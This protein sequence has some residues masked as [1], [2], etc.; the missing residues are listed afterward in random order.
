MKGRY[1]LLIMSAALV[2]SAV[3]GA[4]LYSGFSER[5][6]G[7]LTVRDRAISGTDSTAVTAVPDSDVRSAGTETVTAS[8]SMTETK[9]TTVTTEK[10]KETTV[11]TTT[12]AV[13]VTREPYVFPADINRVSAEQLESISGIGEVIA[14]E[15]ISYRGSHGGFH[16]LEELLQVNGIGQNRYELLKN[17]LYIT[18]DM[19]T[20]AAVTTSLPEAETSVITTTS[21]TGSVTEQKVTITTTA[22]KVTTTAASVTDAPE[23]KVVNINEASLEEL[24]ECLLLDHDT[25]EAIVYFREQIGEY[26]NVLELLYVDDLDYKTASMSYEKFNA[27][28]DYCVLE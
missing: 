11:V 1:T 5:G 16:S 25:A 13:S 7:D 8:E 17:Y 21:A 22:G 10:E 2:I 12:H 6:S 28:K 18:D 19:T 14:A 9:V 3:S 27:I 23:R 24:E 26:V 15:I 20:T 4:A